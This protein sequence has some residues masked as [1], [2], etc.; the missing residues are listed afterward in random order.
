MHDELEKIDPLAAK[1]IH[2]NDARRLVR[3]LE[4]YEIT[5]K[6]ISQKKT[7]RQGI[8]GEY[9][10]KIFLLERD[11]EELYARINR[12]V[13]E[14]MKEGL[15]KEAKRLLQRKLSKTASGALG[16]KEMRAHVKGEASLETAIEMLKRN[17]RH[18]A[19]RQ[20]SWFRH[21]RGVETMHVGPDEKASEIAHRIVNAVSL[22]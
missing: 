9:D 3:A 20:L 7:Q 22:P 1:K 8:R 4:V 15:L 11:R 13:D 18:Y 16:L 21:E 12:R 6:P 5:G 2:R 14:M 17:T 19:K 10:V